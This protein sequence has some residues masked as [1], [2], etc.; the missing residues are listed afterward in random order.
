MKASYHQREALRWAADQ[1]CQPDHCGSVCRCGPC[2]AREALAVLD[3]D[4]R[5]RSSKETPDP[6]CAECGLLEVTTDLGGAVLS[7]L[8]PH[9]RLCPDCL[10]E[11]LDDGKQLRATV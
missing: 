7:N 10:K 2:H 3:P 5:P 4:Y 6:W 9:S 11:E 8:S 1:P